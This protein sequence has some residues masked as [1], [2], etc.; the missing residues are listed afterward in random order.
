MDDLAVF[1][2]FTK[3]ID[4]SFRMAED[5]QVDYVAVN[6]MVGQDAIRKKSGKNMVYLKALRT[7]QSAIAGRKDKVHLIN[8]VNE[9]IRRLKKDGILD[10]LYHLPEEEQQKKPT[11]RKNESRSSEGRN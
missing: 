9:G 1:I 3:D 8:S 2:R 11:E 10:R 4:E 7:H 5:G 6:R